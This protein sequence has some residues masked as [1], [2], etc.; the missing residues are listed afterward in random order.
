MNQ[1]QGVIIISTMYVYTFTH[2]F[3]ILVNIHFS[4]YVRFVIFNINFDNSQ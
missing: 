3:M 1:L 4:K 2:G